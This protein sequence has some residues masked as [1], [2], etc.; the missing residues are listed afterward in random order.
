VTSY[1]DTNLQSTVYSQPTTFQYTYLATP[2]P[3]ID[4]LEIAVDD[5]DN[6]FD[7]HTTSSLLAGQ[8]STSA[9]HGGVQ[10]QFD[11]DGNGTVDGVAISDSFGAIMYRPFG[12][13]P[14]AVEIN[15]RVNHWNADQ[16]QWVTGP[17]KEVSF[18]LEASSASSMNVTSLGLRRD[19]G[20]NSTRQNQQR[21]DYRRSNWPLRFRYLGIHF[22]TLEPTC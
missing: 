20:A 17:W 14:G 10:I 2:L 6:A 11:H 16:A 4:W 3:S 12:L 7:R 5:G 21:R 18:V 19:T 22:L 8:L 13:A 15:A 1:W 9:V